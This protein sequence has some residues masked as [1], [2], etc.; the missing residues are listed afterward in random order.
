[1]SVDLKGGKRSSERFSKACKNGIWAEAVFCLEIVARLCSPC[2]SLLICSA[3]L[4][5]RLIEA[6]CSDPHMTK[7][8]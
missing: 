3:E 2:L 1:M 4:Y 5:T 6:A 8:H 7:N